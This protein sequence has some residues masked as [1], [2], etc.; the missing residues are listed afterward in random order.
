M[1]LAIIITVSITAVALISWN[2]SAMYR[3]ELDYRYDG[4]FE[5]RRHDC[6]LR[7]A[8]LEAGIQCF[9]GADQSG[10]YLLTHPARKN[11]FWSFGNARGVF[12]RNLRIPWS[13]LGCRAGRM[14]LLDCIWFDIPSR[15]IHFYVPRNIGEE[16]LR[17]SNR[18]IPT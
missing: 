18:T 16:L 13:D 5:G 2:A 8:N 12:K 15:K 17:D 14:L 4:G 11:S 6:T 7:F 1:L 10:L 3:F 9:I